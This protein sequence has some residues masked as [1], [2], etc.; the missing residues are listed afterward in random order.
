MSNIYVFNCIL[1]SDNN[2]NTTYI[3]SSDNSS[4]NLPYFQIEHPRFLY[5]QI[6]YEIKNFF[7]SKKRIP[8]EIIVSY[9][10]PENQFLLDHIQETNVYP[11]DI[12]KDFVLLSS[13]ILGFKDETSLFWKKHDFHFDLKKTNSSIKLLIDYVV[14]RNL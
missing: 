5:N 4:I 3:L 2:E 9:L 8:E 13:V 14:Q 11:I 12:N 1:T 7:I 10:D 6:R